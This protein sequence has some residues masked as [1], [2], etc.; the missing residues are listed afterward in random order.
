MRESWLAFAARETPRYTSYPTA[1][2]FSAA[3]GAKEVGGWASAID[4]AH[5]LSIYVHVPFCAQLCWYC[6]CHTT[7]PNGY[8]RATR[9][10]RTLLREIDLWAKRLGPHRGAHHVH[11]GGGTPSFLTAADLKT[12]LSAIDLAF[13]I[14]PGAEIAIEIDPR[15][16]D[17]ARIAGLSEAGFTRASLGAQDFDARVQTAVNRIQPF[18]QVAAVAEALR[19]A[20][21]ERLNLDLMYG[22]PHQT[23]DSVEQTQKLA[24][25]LNPDRVAVFGYAHV[26]WF[27]RHQAMI[28]E[29][30]L[31]DI[32]QR[33]LQAQA[34]ADV[35]ES[36]GYAPI[37]F[38][39]YAAPEDSLTAAA[40][41]GR[42][43]RNFQ[44]YTDDP[45]DALIGLGA[46]SISD[47]PGGMAQNARDIADWTRMIEAGALPIDRGVGRTAE[48][49]LRGLAI[50][51]LLCAM[52]VDLAEICVSAGFAEDALD[53]CLPGLRALA[54]EALCVVE[55][56]RVGIPIAARLLART[57]A[58]RLDAY[59]KDAPQRH[60]VSV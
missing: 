1:A 57:V 16:V 19:A 51:R 9:Y 3:I 7:I 56:R 10:V 14:A 41:A 52:S 15:T 18:E 5:R 22:L 33:L 4:R 8:D 2:Q 60:S 53:D 30:E 59:A 47:F 27:K 54:D 49:R 34:A 43:R 40:R 35:W 45:A 13:S 50:E 48:D 25:S 29:A 17:A 20:G 12:I 28:D 44:G 32:A 6:G 46:S 36:A 39:H 31:P 23:V 24:A 37:G 42:L 38:D 21:I 11:F 26:P 55:G 58:R